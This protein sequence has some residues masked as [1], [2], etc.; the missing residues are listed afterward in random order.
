[1]TEKMTPEWLADLQRQDQVAFEKLV[2]TYH[3][4]LTAVARGIVGDAH[5]ED[6]VQE[7]WISIHRNL[8]KFE[9]RSALS[10]WMYAI[11]SNAG[12]SRLRKDSKMRTVDS[13]NGDINLYLETHLNDHEHWSRVLPHWDIQSPDALLQESQLLKCIK[14]TTEL[15][16]EQQRA[17]FTLRDIEQI[18][19]NEISN[20]L[21]ISDSNVRVLL[22][23]ARLK[24][25]QVIDHYQET[26]TC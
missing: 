19:L 6:V 5:A 17:V 11:V 3:R 21:D 26:G 10:T 18:S 1:M 25:M 14:K 9:G 22:H 8:P 15:L 24:L 23:R 12:R 2:R 4:Q 13:D 7:A 16:S 20:I